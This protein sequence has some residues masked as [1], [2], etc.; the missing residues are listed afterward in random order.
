MRADFSYDAEDAY[1]FTSISRY[2]DLAG[3]ELVATSTYGYD[4]ADRITSLTH[5]DSGSSTLAGYTWGYD[6]GNRLT[7]FTVTGYS[8]EDATYTYDDTDQLTRAD[9]SG[10]TS[11]ESYT[12]D[13][14]GNRTGGSY[15]TGDNTQILSDGTYNYTYDDEGNRLTKTNIS[16]GEV[17]EYEWDYRNRLIGITT[18]TSG[19]TVTHEVEY[20]YDVFNRRIVKTIDADG[21]GSGTPTEEVYIYDGLREERGAAGDHML[22]RFDEADDL[23]DR[24]MYGPNVDQILATEEVTSTSSAGDVLW[25]LTD[26]LGTVRDVVDYDNSTDTTTVQNHLAYNSFGN[27]VSETNTAVD[28]LFA[29]TGRER[30][31]E[32]DLQYNRARYYDSAVGRWISEDPIGFAARDENLFRYVGNSPV[33]FLDSSGHE[34][35]NIAGVGTATATVKT[36]DA[37]LHIMPDPNRPYLYFSEDDM[38]RNGNTLTY[39]I[40]Y[41]GTPST[42]AQLTYGVVADFGFE[43]KNTPDDDDKASTYYITTRQNFVKTLVQGQKQESHYGEVRDDWVTDEKHWTNGKLSYQD[44]PSRGISVSGLNISTKQGVTKDGKKG[45]TYT[46]Q[47]GEKDR[48]KAVEDEK[49]KKAAQN[50]KKYIARMDGTLFT[51]RL[52]CN[53]EHIGEWRWAYAVVTKFDPKTGDVTSITTQAAKIEWVPAKQ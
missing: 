36:F 38:T 17:I 2:A 11:D 7:D 46:V 24:L 29:F 33:N 41:P 31:E 21:A 5:A 18:K 26:H 20:T 30:D 6:E 37:K 3:T 39:S 52:Y 28:F 35:K 43:P 25:A 34:T 44:T 48:E 1:Q 51:T 45:W 40:E 27:I 53:Y 42:N 49:K 32:S 16:T 13:E 23:T 47:W 15:S 10:T 12:Y 14:N 8:A 19:G 50:Q 22:L 9:R 4:A